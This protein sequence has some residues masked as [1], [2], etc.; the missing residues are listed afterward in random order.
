MVSGRVTVVLAGARLE[1]RMEIETLGLLRAGLPLLR[2]RMPRDL[3]RDIALIKARL[4]EVRRG[5]G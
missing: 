5:A 3:A 2:R 1:S 4:E